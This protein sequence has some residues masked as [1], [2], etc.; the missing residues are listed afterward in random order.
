M[1][2]NNMDMYCDC[3]IASLFELLDIHLSKCCESKITSSQ[4]AAIDAFIDNMDLPTTDGTSLSASDSIPRFCIKPNVAKVASIIAIIATYSRCS[5]I[6]IFDKKGTSTI[7]Y[8]AMF[9]RSMFQSR[10]MTVTFIWKNSN[11]TFEIKSVNNDETIS[12]S[13]NDMLYICS[14]ILSSQRSLGFYLDDELVPY[15]AHN[16][17]REDSIWV[18]S[19][20]KSLNVVGEVCSQAMALLYDTPYIMHTFNINIGRFSI[21]TASDIISQE[22]INSLSTKLLS[23]STK[24]GLCYSCA[25][26]KKVHDITCNKVTSSTAS[27]LLE[28][29]EKFHIEASEKVQTDHA[30]L[31]WTACYDDSC[32]VHLSDKEGS[33]WF[34]K[35]RHPKRE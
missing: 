27:I 28:L 21:S 20:N 32:W 31:S 29:D 22:Q 18:S 1:Q 25:F 33:G 30:S 23:A 16:Q 24:T 11:D 17:T 7:D 2:S 10:Q 9:C 14:T 4:Y 15:A 12:V 13:E 5:D 3:A 6:V 35:L 8:L 26:M 19:F 34:P